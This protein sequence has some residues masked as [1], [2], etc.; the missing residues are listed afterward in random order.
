M[1]EVSN[2]SELEKQLDK[3]KNVLALFYASWCPFCRSFLAVFDRNCAQYGSILALR[4]RVDDE[5]NPLWQE[6]SIGTVPTV[7]LFEEGKVCRRLDGE[8]GSG[9]NE[10]QLEGLMK[11]L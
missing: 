11:K 7:I 4:V 9:L 3:S 8:L 10:K 6:Y 5:E 2:K 1:I